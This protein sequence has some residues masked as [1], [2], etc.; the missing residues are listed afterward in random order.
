MICKENIFIYSTI[1]IF[2]ACTFSR[3]S[4]LLKKLKINFRLLDITC[5]VLVLFEKKIRF[6]CYLETSPF[7]TVSNKRLENQWIIQLQFLCCC[8]VQES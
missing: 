2:K 8:H 6:L 3:V 5:A 7:L 1:L 4:D